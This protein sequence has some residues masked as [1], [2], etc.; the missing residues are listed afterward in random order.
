MQLKFNQ[1]KTIGQSLMS[2]LIKV[3]IICLLFTLAIFLLEKFNFPS[4]K[5]NIKKDITNEIIKLK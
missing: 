1:R 4:P 5:Q 3:V 2:K